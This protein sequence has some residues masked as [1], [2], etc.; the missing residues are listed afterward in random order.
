MA[1]PLPSQLH[2]LVANH[3]VPPLDR[4]AGSLRLFR[5]LELLSEDGHAVTLLA[6]AG[7]GQE[8][9]TAHVA[10]LGIEV[11]PVDYD[12]LR[13]GGIAAEGASV[14]VPNLLVDR[15]FD[16]ALLSHFEIA[17]Q[18][19]PL[20]R[21]VSPLTRV[22]IDT[23]DVHY[24]RE[25]RG[26]ELSGDALALAAAERTRRREQ[27][28][29]PRA[30]ALIAVSNEEAAVLGELAPDVSRFVVS[31]VHAPASET[32]QFEARSGVVFVGNFKHTPNVDAVLDFHERV[33]PLIKPGLP[34]ARLTIVGAAP[35]EAVLALGRDDVDVT[36]WVP[37]VEPYLDAARVSVAP[38]RYGAGVKGKIGEA[39]GR[40]LPVVTTR[41]G[42]EGMELRDGEHALVA[43]GADEFARA[44][45]NLHQDPELWNRVSAAGRAHIDERLGPEA[46]RIALRSLLTD[47][48]PTPF[49]MS[50]GNAGSASTI[51]SYA[52]TFSP[53][54]PVS[55]VITVPA[56]DPAAAQS[57]FDAAAA[58]LAGC[59]VPVDAV[60]DIQIVPSSPELVLPSRAVH[61]SGGEA[62]WREL[63]AATPAR[64]ARRSTPRAAVL[65]HALDDPKAVATQIRALERADLPGDVELVIAADA[66]SA[67]VESLLARL[68]G[69]RVI[70]GSRALGRHE[71]WQ[72]AAHATT[73]PFVVGLAAL[74]LPAR[75]FVQPLVEA[76]HHGAALAGPVV[77]G[78]AG[79]RVAPDGSLWP[80]DAEDSGSP[81]A[82]SLDCIASTRELM[83]EGW[84]V[85]PLVDGHIETQLAEWARER[86]GIELA[87]DARVDRVPAPPATVIV[88]T[89]NRS[90]ELPDAVALLMNSGAHD[91]VIVDNNSSDATADVAA[92]LAER[93]GGL[94]RVVHEPREG[95]SH[96]RNAGAV[97]AHHDLL[98]YIDDDARPAP[99]WLNHIAWALSR[100]GVVNAGGPICG[101][102]V[103]NRPPGWPGRDREAF[104]GILDLG[105][106]ERAI[107][108][109]HVVY[110]GNWAVRR[111]ALNAVGGFDPKWGLGPDSRIGGEE[112]SIAWLLH[113]NRVGSTVYA[114]GAAVGHRISPARVDDWSLL[115]R[116]IGS[117]IEQPRMQFW[118]GKAKQD[119]LVAWATSAATRL[120]A[121]VPLE[122][123]LSVRDAFERIAAGPADVNHQ[124]SSALALGELAATAALLG[125]DEVL[126]GQLR[127]RIERDTLLRGFLAEPAIARVAS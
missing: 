60:A 88:A 106:V 84:P 20:I 15:R 58:T 80:R 43:D 127:L 14:D 18:Y 85:F 123:E 17:E 97:A 50:A 40:G 86:G 31:T 104:L 44:V 32:P 66:P 29:Y 16:V 109:P 74:A 119:D 124:L 91:V 69:A 56:D 25:R 90:D 10:G 48:V 121:A 52:R 24:L 36:G 73:A 22:V 126:A 5:L 12:R 111:Q 82:I 11:F 1:T 8:R 102:W 45:L 101:L 37:Q 108:P 34:G 122:G 112:V 98:V 75:G 33:W 118:L 81:D 116:A 67:A 9:A 68:G 27:A 114:P 64:A 94:V 49:V 21:K 93:S 2:I 92:E 115:H 113:R 19:L 107:A 117:A 13:E 4:D 78:A 54:D 77:A 65:L 100:P 23:V 62:P 96:A 57:A 87:G 41:V 110:G 79:L 59:G 125:E 38:L 63:V 42:A 30:D 35:P 3:D 83:A 71:A 47:I 39:L 76:L 72:L 103:E 120:L 28:I 95:L 105:E 70:R 61:I 6:L 89:R 55:L 53:D 26:A 99:G 51:A 46:A 7:V